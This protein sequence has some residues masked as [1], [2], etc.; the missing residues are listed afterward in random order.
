MIAVNLLGPAR[1]GNVTNDRRARRTA[2]IGVTFVALAVIGSGMAWWSTRADVTRLDR[3]M[4][5]VEAEA[6]RLRA[7][8]R[9]AE[10]MFARR[11]ALL[12]RQTA[13]NRE[14]ETR[15]APVR[16]LETIGQSLP[17]DVW[18]TSLH[19][20]G[21]RLD[22]DGRALSLQAITDFAARIQH[23][24]VVTT[25]VEVLSTSSETRDG[26]TLVRFSLRLD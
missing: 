20:R 6:V 26:T 22:I 15:L 16:V 10:H 25:P 19:Q 18:L 5:N 1:P 3:E 2:W 24:G 9:D 11:T 12:D 8:S 21:T 23:A 13:I 17:A 4:A 14:H 7:A